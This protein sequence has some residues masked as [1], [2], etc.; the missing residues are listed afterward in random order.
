MNAP[1]FKFF[2]GDYLNDRDVDDLPLEPQGILIRMWCLL[3]LDGSLPGDVEELARRCKIRLPAMQLHMQSLLQFFVQ[4]RD[5]S[6]VSQRMESERERSGIVSKAR[7]N[8]AKKRWNKG[9]DAIASANP[10]ANGH[11][12]ADANGH[13]NAMHVRSQMSDV[14][15]QKSKTTSCGAPSKTN[16]APPQTVLINLPLIDGSEFPIT[17]AAAADWQT[18]FPALDVTQQLRSM[19]S[20]CLANSKNRK[21]RSGILR[22]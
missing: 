13:A 20:W 8:A 15:S 6:L 4:Q 12:K 19:R 21:T 22:F 1:Y 18:L 3:W 5:G 10:A 9:P 2:A 11:A 16:G 17:E 7:H 14:K